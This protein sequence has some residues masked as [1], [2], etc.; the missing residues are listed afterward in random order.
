MSNSFLFSEIRSYSSWTETLSSEEL[1]GSL[2]N[3]FEE[4]VDAVFKYGGTLNKYIGDSLMGMFGF[5]EPLKEDAWCAM[6]AAVEMRNR[7]ATF[8]EKQEAKRK[9]PV[10]MGI[11]IHSNE[12]LSGNIGSSKHMD[13]T[14]VGDAF[15]FAA[16]LGEMSR[17]YGTDLVISE[18]TYRP[19]KDRLWVRELDL[20][21]VKGKTESVRI[22]ELVGIRKGPLRQRLKKKQQD[23]I[24]HYHKGREYYLRPS[25][26]KLNA[27]G[28]R[29]SFELAEKEFKAVLKVDPENK[30]AKLHIGRCLLFQ[31]ELPEPDWDGAWR[32]I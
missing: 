9:M 18:N 23:I 27:D 24:G 13:L 25:I 30:A 19:Y 22:Y 31:Q 4:M 8:N 16:S 32:W 15:S 26:E 7:L 5:P 3:Y 6:Q 17:K 20:T 2:D 21:A 11:G 29:E 1:V 28:V 14:F 12:V 10:S